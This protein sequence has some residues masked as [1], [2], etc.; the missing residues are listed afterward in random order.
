M[1]YCKLRV[2]L[3]TVFSCYGCRVLYNS[4]MKGLLSGIATAVLLLPSCM[5]LT[6]EAVVKSCIY[7]PR[8]DKS[9]ELQI[10]RVDDV[11]YLKLGV[12]Y[13]CQ[14][15]AVCVGGAMAV[16]GSE[17]KLPISYHDE[18][19]PQAMYVLMDSASVKAFLGVKPARHQDAAPGYYTEDEWDATRATLC[20]PI[21]PLPKNR[22]SV[23]S[24][25]LLAPGCSLWDS[26]DDK[27]DALNVY[28][29][30]IRG[31]DAAYKYPLAALLAVGVDV[32]GTV[33]A[34]GAVMAGSLVAA[35]LVMP[36]Q[37]MSQQTDAE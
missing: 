12:R 13:V 10:Y 19:A 1:P 9:Q 21:R 15:D 7:E 23:F 16:P 4:A 30:T 14:A 33:I 24:D 20:K 3:L 31:W 36:V 11:Y 6:S 27:W 5:V 17:V 22:I 25:H 35:P 32:P 34:T 2:Q 28:L 37:A 18:L 8:E 26:K 29:P